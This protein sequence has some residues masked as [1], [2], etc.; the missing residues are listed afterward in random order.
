MKP[1][2]C[3][4][5]SLSSGNLLAHLILILFEYNFKWVSRG[6]C[7][8][9]VWAT[10]PKSPWTKTSEMIPIDHGKRSHNMWERHRDWAL[11]VQYLHSAYQ[12]QANQWATTR[13]N[14]SIKNRR[15]KLDS[16][17]RC[18]ALATRPSRNNLI[19]L[20]KVQKEFLSIKN[21]ERST[22]YIL[23]L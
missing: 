3:G 10:F 21:H 8:H 13:K 19:T 11:K 12:I 22:K 2:L 16:K 15:A 9:W 14:P 18:K 5:I 7:S 1:R 6:K 4:N 20:K 17:N 23:L